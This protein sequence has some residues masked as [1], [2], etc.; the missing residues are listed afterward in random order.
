MSDQTKSLI[1]H[2]LTALGTIVTLIGLNTWVPILT[3]LQTHLDA[4][5]EAVNVV[6]G[7]IVALYGF[8]FK[9]SN[10]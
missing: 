7:V 4:V 8:F 1:R 2:I 6:I 5:W 10:S 3:F 9:R